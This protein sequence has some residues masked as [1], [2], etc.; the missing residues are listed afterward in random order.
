[1]A[2]ESFSRGQRL[3]ALREGIRRSGSL[4]TAFILIGFLGLLPVVL[5]LRRW[6]QG[7]EAVMV[8]AGAAWLLGWVGVGF[9]MINR[10]I[11][12]EKARAALMAEELDVV[13][14]FKPYLAL[15]KF[16]ANGELDKKR[17]KAFGLSWSFLGRNY[18]KGTL[19]GRAIEGSY[20]R[21]Y[22]ANSE[23]SGTEDV[24][25][26]QVIVLQARG[27]FPGKLL[28]M[29]RNSEGRLRFKTD[30]YYDLPRQTIGEVASNRKKRREAVI[31]ISGELDAAWEA[32]STEP[33]LARAML[34]EG[35]ALHEKL[36]GADRLD[37]ALYSDDTIVLGGQYGF[38]LSEGSADEARERCERALDGL[39]N[40][41][42]PAVDSAVFPD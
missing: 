4:G 6:T 10:S 3:E 17:L 19:D 26:G 40:E 32:M 1:M 39:F 16:D 28:A 37:F 31:S 8:I 20:I 42:I 13:S 34:G 21:F 11:A 27:R 23:G 7:S 35:T 24:W 15:E 18:F 36:L 5:L 14:I 22:Q 9:F 2:Y 38:D 29:R 33:D 30:A 41:A 25:W 12:Q